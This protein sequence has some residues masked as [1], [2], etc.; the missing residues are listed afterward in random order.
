V[1]TADKPHAQD[2]SCHAR[3]IDPPRPPAPGWAPQQASEELYDVVE[4]EAIAQRADLIASEARERYDERHDE[5]D[6][7]EQGAEA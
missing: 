3:K 6:D 1:V 4:P 5:Y 7:P 2:S